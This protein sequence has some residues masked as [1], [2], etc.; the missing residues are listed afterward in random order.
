MINE[1]LQLCIS[2]GLWAVLFVFLFSYQLKTNE[3]REK[4]YEATISTLTEYVG[5]IKNCGQ[6]LETINNNIEKVKKLFLKK[7]KA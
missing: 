4:K 5:V 2:N 3:K 7:A 6:K 1:I